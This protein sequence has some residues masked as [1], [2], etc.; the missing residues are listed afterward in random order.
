MKNNG[1]LFRKEKFN[2]KR[3]KCLIYILLYCAK[4]HL[5]HLGN[6][7]LAVYMDNGSDR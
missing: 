6:V 1:K 7:Y 5:E 2:K 3:E 4:E